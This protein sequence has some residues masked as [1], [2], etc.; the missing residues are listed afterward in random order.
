M[1]E[2]AKKTEAKGSFRDQFHL[3]IK[4]GVKPNCSS[5]QAI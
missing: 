5:Y 4:P 2:K 3:S 1:P